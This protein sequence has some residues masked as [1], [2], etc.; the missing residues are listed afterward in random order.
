MKVRMRRAEIAGKFVESITPD[1]CAR[2]NLEHAV[3]GIKLVDRRAPT[4]RVS[5][6]ED[7][8]KV[9]MKQFVDSVIHTNFDV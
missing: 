3:F 2:W 7:L 9:T 1:E 8:L 5:L 6:A 4:R